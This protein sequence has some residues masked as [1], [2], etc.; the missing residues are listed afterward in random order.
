MHHPSRIHTYTR[1]LD[2]RHDGRYTIV[3]PR[4]HTQTRK[5]SQG[6]QAP[7]V[8]VARL[9]WCVARWR[10]DWI[11]ILY[12][13]HSVDACIGAKLTLVH[14]PFLHLI[15]PLD[16][17]LPL[18]CSCL[19]SQSRHGRTLAMRGQR[20]VLQVTSLAT[21]TTVCW[22]LLRKNHLLKIHRIDSSMASGRLQAASCQSAYEQSSLGSNL[23]LQTSV[24]RFV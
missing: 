22:L 3:V 4:S 20:A 6:R 16:L 18:W 5:K 24:E 14:Q 23:W 9:R 11:H 19:P 12:S 7:H 13:F 21:C 2:T 8:A 1:T 10:I 15:D 17:P